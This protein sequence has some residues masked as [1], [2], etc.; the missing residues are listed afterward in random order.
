[1]NSVEA[2]QSIGFNRN[3]SKIYL[4]V[5]ELG[6]STVLPIAKKSGIKRT[7]CYDILSS[8]LEKGAISF[9]EKRGRRRFSAVE[10]R[11]IQKIFEDKIKKFEM[12]VPNLQNIYQKSSTR[13]IARFL[14]GKTGIE[15]IFQEILKEAKEVWSITSAT[16][17]IEAFPDY[18]EYVNALAKAKIKIYDLVK[19]SKE[20][21]EYQ[22][23]YKKPLQEARYLPKNSQ[24][25]TDFIV[26]NDKFVMIC[27]G[28]D[29]HT[30]AVESPQIANSMKDLHKL[31]WKSAKII[32]KQP[33]IA[34]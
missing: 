26:W 2:L 24:Y 17:W 29:I 7:Y 14:E 23:L 1:M 31:L 25:S 16:D 4:A 15:I 9:V 6:E 27:Y 19:F 5:L 28:T 8:L 11:M 21:V 34:P 12:V 33:L 10:P 22:K 30:V 32:N 13:P 20:G 18:A 3:E